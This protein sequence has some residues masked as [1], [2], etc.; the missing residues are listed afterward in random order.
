MS[1]LS[2]ASMLVVSM[3][4]EKYFSPL[5][6]SSVDHHLS[7]P[8][9]INA[10]SAPVSRGRPFACKEGRLVVIFAQWPNEC[11]PT[12]GDQKRQ[13]CGLAL[14][15]AQETGTCAIDR[16]SVWKEVGQKDGC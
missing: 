12:P 8:V 5:E 13:P 15:G 16:G 3:Y 7:L 9:E 2:I 4:G 1:S 6:D 11:E 10:Q 14:E